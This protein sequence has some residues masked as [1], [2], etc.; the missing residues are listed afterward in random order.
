M[1]VMRL[2]EVRPLSLR[3][4]GELWKT[5]L[6]IDQVWQIVKLEAARP[7]A[8]DGVLAEHFQRRHGRGQ[9]AAHHAPPLPR[10]RTSGHQSQTF[11]KGRMKDRRHGKNDDQAESDY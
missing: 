5:S 1:V 4:C 6:D 8:C 11:R 3:E 7:N 10:S 2:P 9:S